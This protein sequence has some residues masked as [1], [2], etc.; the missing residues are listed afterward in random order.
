MLDMSPAVLHS[1][2]HT[3]LVSWR[4]LLRIE[5]WAHSWAMRESIHMLVVTGQVIRPCLYE[6]IIHS[7]I[8]HPHDV[9]KET[10]DRG[11]PGRR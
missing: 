8:T 9:D 1:S 11:Q 5:E 4:L 2:I 6:H 10:V 7:Y 3:K